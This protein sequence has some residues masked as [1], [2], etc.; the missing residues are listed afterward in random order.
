MTDLFMAILNMSLTGAFVIAAVCLIRFLLKR[1]PKI[2]SYCLWLVVGLRLVLPIS[3]NSPVGLVPFDAESITANIPNPVQA[4]INTP[5]DALIA[6]ELAAAEPFNF[7]LAIAYIWLGGVVLMLAYGI[8][9]YY[10]LSKKMRAG[11]HIKGNIYEIGNIDTPF[12]FGFIAPK[13]YLPVGLERDVAN[14]AILH[15]QTH[16]KY[17]DHIVKLMSF[18]ILCI[19]WFN[20]MVWLAFHQMSAD[21]EMAC[22]ER[23]VKEIGAGA[24]TAY[25]QSLVNLATEARFARM[26]PLAFGEGGAKQRVSNVLKMKKR[27]IVLTIVAV[28]IVAGVGIGLLLNQPGE[29]PLTPL[30]AEEDATEPE[31]TPEPIPTPT[32]E[33]TPTPTPEPTPE[34]TPA[35]TPEPQYPPLVLTPAATGT[36][37]M[38]GHEILADFSIPITFLHEP[39]VIHEKDDVSGRAGMLGQFG[40]SVG[41]VMNIYHLRGRPANGSGYAV[42]VL[43]ETTH[44]LEHWEAIDAAVGVE[45]YEV[46]RFSI[47]DVWQEE[48]AVATYIFETPGTFVLE[49]R[50]R[51]VSSGPAQYFSDFIVITVE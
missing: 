37:V 22:D 3:I 18:L 31:V 48:H 19:H 4:I 50:F 30:I 44:G 11:S 5:Q 49:L 20:P 15:E 17:G 10:L 1:H 24:K 12:V 38:E 36:V 40:I 51:S 28:L 29:N 14:H 45:G 43:V 8:V 27:S 39:T 7:L 9:S 34:P 16:I 23:V 35:P 25:S 26:S 33:P 42:Y 32:P 21:M 6:T 41:N 13:I 47:G 2:I 46:A